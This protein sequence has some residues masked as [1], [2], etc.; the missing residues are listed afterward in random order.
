MHLVLSGEGATD[1]GLFS[2]SDNTFIPG[3]MYYIIDKIIEKKYD[4]SYYLTTPD[5][6]TF[7]PKAKLMEEARKIRVFAG[8]KREKETTYFYKNAIVLSRIAKTV[9]QEKEDNDV[10]A[11]LFRDSDGTNSSPNT[12]WDKKVA[13]IKDAF[14]VESIKGVPMVPKPKSEAWLICALK[15]DGYQ[16]CVPL[17]S[18][19]GNDNSPRALKKELK[20]ILDEKKLEYNDIN[21]LIQDDSICI[22]KIRM[23]SYQ[24][25]FER[26]NELL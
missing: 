2:Y 11:I 13:S 21:E 6:I 9:C 16:N 1:I 17:E 12:L 3:A 19:S 24:Y 4:F 8:K 15:E 20:E 22:E 7:I 5:M 18:R 23:P 10:I 25:F 26:L 14:E